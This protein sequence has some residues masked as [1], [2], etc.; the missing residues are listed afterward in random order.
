MAFEVLDD[1]GRTARIAAARECFPGDAVDMFVEGM[2]RTDQLVDT[3][4]EEL[5]EC[6]R[7]GWQALDQVLSSGRSMA[8]VAPASLGPLLDPLMSPPSWFDAEQVRWGAALWWRFWLSNQIGLAGSLRTGYKFGDLNKPQAMNGRSSVMAARRYEETT[9]WVLDATEPGALV[10]GGNGFKATVKIRLV[11]AMVRRRL[12]RDPNWDTAAWGEPIHTSGM[13]VT[14]IA[15]LILPLSAMKMVGV[16]F[17][18]E[19]VEAIRALWHWTCYLM[20]VPE[21]LLP[22]TLDHAQTVAELA[23]VIFAPPDDD[24]RMLDDALMRNGIRAEH[25]LPN[26][27]QP[28][29]APIL[30]PVI[31]YGIWGVSNAIVKQMEQHADDLG[32]VNHPVVR[33]LRRVAARR[34]RLRH[35]GK[36]GSDF[37][38]AARQRNAVVTALQWIDA[39]P[40]SLQPRDAMT[41]TL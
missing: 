3:V 30:R 23:G 35:T 8:D 38:I 2:F 4:A 32:A 26:F 40:Q 37:E 7:A 21:G 25:A 33:V 6:G 29:M 12:R 5:A 34:E 28:V 9:R 22:H 13:A 27:L 1:P 36:L 11:H 14:G 20:G 17:T 18:D 31:S 39:A 10:P 19:E 15:F 24:S 41:V 16:E